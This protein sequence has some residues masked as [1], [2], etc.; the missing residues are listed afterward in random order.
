MEIKLRKINI[1]YVLTAPISHIGE[2]A[3]TGAYFNTVKTS[4]GRL[5]VITGN[6]IRGQ[7]RDAGASELLSR[8]GQQVDKE[9]FHVLFSGGNVSAS[10]RDDIARAIEIREHFPLVSL[11]GGA[12]GTMIMGGKLLCGFAYPVCRESQ[13]I[14]GI[15]SGVSWHELIDEIEFTRVDDAKNDRLAQI[16][17]DVNAETSGQASQQMRYSVQYMAPG[18]EFMQCMTLLPGVTDAEIG[19][20]M[21]AMAWWWS[22]APRLGGMGAKGFGA[23]NALANMDGNDVIEVR[24]GKCTCNGDAEAFINEYR[25]ASADSAQFMHLLKGGSDNGKKTDKPAKGRRASSGREDK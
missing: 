5:P 19:A 4:T 23:F 2:V 13:D 7:I 3:S 17:S 15:V 9:I 14:T 12:L 18:T 16:I 24:D 22:T 20:L 10:M 21:S 8:L 6:S 11:L 25:D 1:K